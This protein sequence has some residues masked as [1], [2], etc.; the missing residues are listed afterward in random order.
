M[1]K[2]SFMLLLLLIG[3]G[4]APEMKDAPSAKEALEGKTEEEVFAIKYA[5]PFMLNCS[6][7]TIPGT[8]IQ[9]DIEPE[10]EFEWSLDSD[11]SLMRVLHYEVG[12]QKMIVVVKIEKGPEI[13]P[14]VHHTSE[15]F[16]EYY[17]ES[18]PVLTI[19][20]RRA[21]GRILI[22]GS[23]HDERAY[24]HVTLY[25][26]VEKRIF[27]IPSEVKNGILTDDFRCILKTKI[28]PHFKEQWKIIR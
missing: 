27:T 5:E 9:K 12:A 8:F 11:L 4:K 19:K 28:H 23:V 22:D 21:P 15:D 17:M 25:E 26:N 14:V 20:Y 24:K 10:D 2:T 6:L 13:K 18:S 3:C 1:L 16:R 7:R